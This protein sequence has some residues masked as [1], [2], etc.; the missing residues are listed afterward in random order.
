LWAALRLKE[1]ALH[2]LFVTHYYEPSA[3]AA[4]IRLTLLARYLQKRG[5]QVTVLTTLPHYPKGVIDLDYRGKLW[6]VETR[7]GVRVIYSW[8]WATTSTRIS[9][10]LLSQMSFMPLGFVRGLG[11]PRPDVTFIEAQPIFTGLVGR[12]LS[13]LKGVPYVLNVSDLW[14]DHM[15]TVGALRETD[16]AYK[17]ARAAMDSSYR[18]AAAITS[19]SPAW[20][21]KIAEYMGGS[22]DKIH[23]IYRGVDTTL[24]QPQRDTGEFRAKYGL[25][26]GKLVTFIGTFA[27][28]YDFD[29]LFAAAA[30]FQERPD[31]RFVIIGTGSQRDTVQAHIASGSAPNV[32]LVDWIAPDEMPLAW[33]ASYLNIW[34][35][36]DTP[37]YYGTLPAKMYEAFATG[38]PI[39][40]AQGGEAAAIL[41]ESG[42]GLTTAPGDTAGL[43]ASIARILEDETLRADMSKR[44]RAYAEQHFAFDAT[45]A[46]YEAVLQQV[47][48]AG[49]HRGKLQDTAP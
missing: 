16:T 47:A 38:T 23:M 33:C 35:M 18:G 2:L 45:A 22:T 43:I 19:M 37:L 26:A 40:A 41:T 32:Q 25:G 5:H 6:K 9:R 28:Q 36:R 15:L 27:T 30:H 10:R 12:A 20:S 34:A 17:I 11:I 42:A 8:L 14:P 49:K 3:G 46:Q 44:A 1:L 39:A 7:D 29:A 31:V 48:N 21:R 4:A 13:R 24:F